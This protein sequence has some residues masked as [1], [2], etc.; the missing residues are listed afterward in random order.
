MN[1]DQISG[2]AAEE[3][4][5][6]QILFSS[7]N[8]GENEVSFSAVPSVVDPGQGQPDQSSSNNENF[9]QGDFFLFP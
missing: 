6:E 3:S 2:L 9:I 4:T 1:F 8:L 7:S 5:S